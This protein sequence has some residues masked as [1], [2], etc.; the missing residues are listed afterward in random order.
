MLDHPYAGHTLWP[1]QGGRSFEPFVIL[2]L[3]IF[4]LPEVP[5]TL[6]IALIL[7][8]V[9]YVLHIFYFV[10]GEPTINGCLYGIIEAYVGMIL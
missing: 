10:S 3:N 4:C 9:T 6:G 8:L 2:L 1:W 7:P 5:L